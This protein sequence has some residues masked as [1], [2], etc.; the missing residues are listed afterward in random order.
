[1]ARYGI[2]RWIGQEPLGPI[3]WHTFAV[4]VVGSFLLGALVGYATEREVSDSARALLAVGILG[5]FT[6]YSSFNT[7]TLALFE[8][9]GAGIAA[10]Y[11]LA[12]VTVCLVAGAGGGWIARQALG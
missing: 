2:A 1:M 10:G 3:P 4:N 11:V 12:T 9:R 7:E 5:G 6:T 8:Q